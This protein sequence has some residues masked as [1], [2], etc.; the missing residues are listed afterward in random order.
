MIQKETIFSGIDILDTDRFRIIADR[1]G[2]RFL[3]KIFTGKELERCRTS[4]KTYDINTLAGMFAAKEACFKALNACSQ[5]SKIFWHDI[6][7]LRD[8]KKNEDLF[9]IKNLNLE[10]TRIIQNALS[11]NSSRSESI[12]FITL[13]TKEV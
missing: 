5:S 4:G 12:A 1:Y 2:E 9:R 7:I 10:K 8:G 13:T 6:E 3:K 11:L